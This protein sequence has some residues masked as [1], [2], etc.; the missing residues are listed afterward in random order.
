MYQELS[1]PDELN[2]TDDQSGLSRVL[3]QVNCTT[4]RTET[5]RK[6]RLRH[7]VSHTTSQSVGRAREA[8]FEDK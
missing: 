1:E 2:T 3:C 6:S 5:T 7:T 4:Y 8:E